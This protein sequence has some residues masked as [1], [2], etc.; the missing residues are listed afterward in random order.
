[1]I[2]S[3][4]DM[5]R[6]LLTEKETILA[7]YRAD[8]VTLGQDVVILKEGSRREAFALDI[9]DQGALILR[10]P[11]RHQETVSAGEVSIRGMYG[12]L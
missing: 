6:K 4:E 10:F 7:Q 9:D 2:L 1:M 3:L 11:D 12:Y 8:C 5:A